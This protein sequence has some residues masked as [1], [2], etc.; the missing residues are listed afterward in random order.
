[1]LT[2]AHSVAT[3]TDLHYP[4][5][6]TPSGPAAARASLR[7]VERPRG[8]LRAGPGVAQGYG[9]SGVGWRTPL[10]SQVGLDAVRADMR[11]KECEDDADAG[12]RGR[13]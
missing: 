13:P 3:L 1:V 9:G 6:P 10:L 4:T 8:V 7:F 2:L 12:S 5:A 11:E